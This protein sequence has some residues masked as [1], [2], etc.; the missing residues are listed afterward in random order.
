MIRQYSI[1]GMSC[2]NCADR[3]KSNLLKHPHIIKSEVYLS[4]KAG[5]I[6]MNKSI[7]LSE[8]QDI[9]SPDG[10]YISRDKM[11]NIL[12]TKPIAKQ[13][14]GIIQ[15]IFYW[16]KKFLTKQNCCKYIVLFSMA[17]AQVNAQNDSSAISKSNNRRIPSVDI[18]DLQGKTINTSS[19]SNSGKPMLIVFW[20]SVHKFPS[21]ELDALKENY[22]DWKNET[23]VKII[24]VSIDDSRSAANV[25]P[26][27]N[28][29]GWDFEFYLDINSDFK[30]EMNVNLVPHSFLINGNGEIIWQKVG[31]MPGDESLIYDELQ[32]L[33]NNLK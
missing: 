20:Y 11:E 17:F 30:R 15:F 23:G 1:G 9:I 27:V 2:Q 19:F 16:L 25:L 24:V 14:K 12:V 5:V 13:K 32:K 8:I 26:L 33:K 21:K 7:S 29:R 6:E 4:A 10:T 3:I 31:F 18:K 22:T 28:A